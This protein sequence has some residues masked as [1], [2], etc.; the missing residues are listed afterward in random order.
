MIQRPSRP[1]FAQK[2]GEASKGK[3]HGQL[4][5]NKIFREYTMLELDLRRDINFNGYLE[6]LGLKGGNAHGQRH[7]RGQWEDKRN[8]EHKINKM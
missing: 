8:L 5:L 1:M 7:S 2:V 3:A 6:I 4:E